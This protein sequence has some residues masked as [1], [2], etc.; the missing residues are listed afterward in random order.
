MDSSI[1]KRDLILTYIGNNYED[2]LKQS[3]R[4]LIANRYNCRNEYDELVSTVVFSI[5][6]RLEDNPFL[7]KC[8]NMAKGNELN[9]YIFK[10]IDINSRSN[11]APFLK[12]KYLNYEYIELGEV[13]V[14]A[15]DND[16]IKFNELSEDKKQKVL[17]IYYLLSD[18][19]ARTLFG[20]HWKY[21]VLLLH[22][23]IDNPK[24]SYKSIARKWGV[25]A[26]SIS[27]HINTIKK[28]ILNKLNT[29][30]NSN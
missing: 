1:M 13:D 5:V 12:D 21:F 29:N 15:M 20:D 17:Q 19:S 11:T 18:T 30:E 2:Y 25:P 16:T 4:K 9:L 7:E 26:S 6:N 3:K 27:Y 8:F 28:V 10:S 22:E 14:E 24:A 23:Y